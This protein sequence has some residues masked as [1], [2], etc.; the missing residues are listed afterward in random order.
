MASRNPTALSGATS[1][2]RA[3]ALPAVPKLDDVR[4]AIDDESN[5]TRLLHR[6][7]QDLRENLLEGIPADLHDVY[8]DLDALVSE[9]GRLEQRLGA[10]GESLDVPGGAEIVAPRLQVIDGQGAT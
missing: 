4:Q 2:V 5:V 1:P 3:S 9:L 10:L 7:A 8:G 6:L